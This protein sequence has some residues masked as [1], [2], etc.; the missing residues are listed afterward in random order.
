MDPKH[1][2]SLYPDGAREREIGKIVTYIKEG[3]S[4]QLIGLPGVGRSSLLG[5]LAY[6]HAIHLK[7]FPVHHKDV[8]FCMLNFSEVRDKSLV[9]VW[10]YMMIS[11][12]SSLQER[13]MSGR[14]DKV[15]AILRKALSYQDE[16]VMSQ[17]LKSVIEYLAVE[18]K[19]TVILLCNKFDS[20]LPNVLKEFFTVL[21]ALRDRA[22]YRFSVIFSL[23]RSLEESVDQDI[24]HDFSDSVSSNSI[25]MSLHDDA[26]IN[27]RL[28]YLEKITQK[29]IPSDV[30]SGIIGLTGG[31]LRLTKL[32]CEAYLEGNSIELGSLI[33]QGKIVSALSDIWNEL[34]PSEQE[35]LLLGKRTEAGVYLEKIGMM[36]GDDIK[37]PLLKS[38]ADLAPKR[39]E[40]ISLDVDSNTIRLGEKALSDDLTKAEYRLLSYLLE[41]R[42]E[43]VGRDEI[44]EH[45]WAQN[46]SVQGVTEQAIDQLVFR[47]RRK[48]EKD[49]NNPSHILT[50]KGRGIKLI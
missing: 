50:V 29:S 28:A 47:L 6:N 36:A 34:T 38:W 2:E 37:I 41:H 23:S 32:I 16:S 48:I 49:P 14:H 26:T 31:H 4:V 27:F 17:G 43:I 20:Y 15:D 8:H 13:G 21:A 24:L 35:V 46:Q 40:D 30:Q 44:V 9:E 11:L 22:K 19:L 5:L 7:H 12:A 25:Y 3:G 18:E 10:K 33:L 1:F 42:E 45:V 39:S